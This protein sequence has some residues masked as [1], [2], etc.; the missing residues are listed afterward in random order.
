MEK[1]TVIAS[2]SYFQQEKCLLIERQATD[3]KKTTLIS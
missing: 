1:T 3:F 2:Q